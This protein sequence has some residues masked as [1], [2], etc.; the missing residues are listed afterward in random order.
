MSDLRV[1]ARDVG[2]GYRLVE[3]EG[4]LGLADADQL[5]RALDDEAAGSAGILVGLQ[6]CDFIDSTALAVL[7]AAHRRFA[8]NGRRLVLCEPTAQVRRVLEVTGLDARGLI[9]DSVEEALD[10]E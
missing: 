7:V 9:Y 10:A 4:E 5:Q 6:G 2:A 8:E 1:S 3:V